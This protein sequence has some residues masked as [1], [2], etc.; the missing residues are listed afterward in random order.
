VTKAGATVKR[1]GLATAV[2]LGTTKPVEGLYWFNEAGYAL[3]V[4]NGKVF[5]ITK[6]SGYSAAE[7]T[8]STLRTFAQTAG[9]GRVVFADDGTNVIM[10]NGG[11]MNY[12][13]AASST[14]QPIGDADAPTA[15]THVAFLDG[16]ILALQ[17]GTNKFNWSEIGASLNWLATSWATAE[18]DADWILHLGVGFKELVLFGE[19]SIEVW[20]NDGVT[21]FAPIPGAFIQRGVS[22]QDSVQ[23][24]NGRWYFLDDQ[25]NFCEMKDRIVQIISTPIEK[26]LKEL[27]N[28][29]DGL[30]D[31]IDI[32]GE[33]FYLMSFPTANRTFVWKVSDDRLDGW[34]EF[35]KGAGGRFLGQAHTRCFGWSADLVGDA[36]TGIVYVMSTANLDD[37]GTAI[38][39]TRRTGW[40]DHG[41]MN[42]K[43]CIA[44]TFKMKDAVNGNVPAPVLQFRYRNNGGVSWSNW[45]SVS[46]TGSDVKRFTQLGRYRTRQWEFKNDQRCLM[47]LVD[48]VEEIEVMTG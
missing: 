47:D 26:E 39:A 43:N 44:L 25:N 9:K 7:M 37:V 30:S 2:D 24:I 48:I 40:L 1:P 4:S 46:M 15:V 12:H 23:F 10:A 45:N 36:T 18:S 29:S 8:G 22:S 33:T 38:T 34:S 20:Y 31:R 3:A 28:L 17:D 14:A 41:T 27:G 19:Q 42:W 11:A 6:P 35:S 5:K 16:R 21:P 32:A 13:V